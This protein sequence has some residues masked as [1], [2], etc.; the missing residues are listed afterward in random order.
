MYSW[1]SED[2]ELQIPNAV[3]HRIGVLGGS[4]TSP[5]NESPECDVIDLLLV[6]RRPEQYANGVLVLRKER[7]DY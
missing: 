5:T 1:L 3:W 7:I 4:S 6:D 2:D